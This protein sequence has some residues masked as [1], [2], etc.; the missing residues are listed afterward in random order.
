MAQQIKATPRNQWQ[1]VLAKPAPT[2]PVTADYRSINLDDT[3]ELLL[4]LRR[5]AALSGNSYSRLVDALGSARMRCTPALR[6]AAMREFEAALLPRL[7]KPYRHFMQ[8]ALA[9]LRSAGSPGL[10]HLPDCQ[11]GN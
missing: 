4:A 3:G 11:V 5:Q 6:A 1:A 10:K 9:P 2:A 8:T 7:A